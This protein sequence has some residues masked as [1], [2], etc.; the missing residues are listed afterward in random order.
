MISDQDRSV[1]KVRFDEVTDLKEEIKFLRDQIEDFNNSRDVS[2]SNLEAKLD[3]EISELREQIEEL[4]NT[5]AEAG[6]ETKVDSLKSEL[7]TFKS[8]DISKAEAGL[9]AKVES[10]K[11]ELDTFRSMDASKA[12]LEAKIESLKSELETFRSKDISKGEVTFTFKGKFAFLKKRSQF[13][14]P[15]LIIFH[16]F[17]HSESNI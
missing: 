6:L 11:S 7:D 9:E 16:L 13:L 14:V 15:L 8:Q 3:E 2:S 12:E 4:V 10:L 5:K 17:F 1:K